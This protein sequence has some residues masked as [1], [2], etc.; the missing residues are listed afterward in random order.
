MERMKLARIITATAF[1]ALLAVPATSPASTR[2]VDIPNRYFQPQSVTVYVGATVRWTNT[3]RERHTVT[4]RSSSADQFTS[5]NNCPGGIF[6]NDCIG[7]GASY[8][9]TFERRGTFTY[10][11]RRH[12]VDAPYPN[13]GM[14][15]RVRVV[16][17]SSATIAPTTPDS[18]SPS[19]TASSPSPSPS[20]SGTK[21][22]SPSASTV[23]AAP[24]GEEDNT[25]A[26][27]AIA[28]V[29]VVFLGGTGFVIYR[30]MIRR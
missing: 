14:C 6:S 23:L 18:A 8:A 19:S 1:V 22:G 16:L 17:R 28:A 12:G 3:S 30:T 29:A 26:L 24:P 25:S 13:C 9:H 21:V 7:P 27:I 15:G 20:I 2:G 10:Y 5:S 11:C 4:A